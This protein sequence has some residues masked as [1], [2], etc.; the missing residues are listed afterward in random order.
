M[1]KLSIFVDESGDFGRYEKHTPYYIVT[2]VFHDQAKDISEGIEKLNEELKNI[3]I[4]YSNIAIH[5]EPLIRREEIYVNVSPNERRAIFTKLF[6][7]TMKASI[8]YKTFIFEKRE[9][10]SAL[11]LEARM[12]REFTYFIRRN[13]S[14]FHIFDKIVLYYDNGQHELTRTQIHRKHRDTPQ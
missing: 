1:S 9:F 4:G 11:E 2:M 6:Y 10:E 12:H 8:S 5:T 3:N 7:F 13:L 14:Y